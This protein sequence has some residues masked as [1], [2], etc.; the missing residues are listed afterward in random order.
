MLSWVYFSIF[1]PATSHLFG[2][3]WKNFNNFLAPLVINP[4]AFSQMKMRYHLASLLQ[5]GP[6]LPTQTK[7]WR[8]F[9]SMIGA[10]VDKNNRRLIA[11]H[12]AM[13]VVNDIWKRAAYCNGARPPQGCTFPDI[14]Q[15]SLRLKFLFSAEHKKAQ[16]LLDY[17][18]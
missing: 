8:L 14:H 4:P 18:Y 9:L 7:S 1:D 12:V 2:R 11:S 6:Q 17:I 13:L 16:N 3:F 15:F 5:N 10:D